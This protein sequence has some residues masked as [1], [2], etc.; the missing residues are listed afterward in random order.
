MCHIAWVDCFCIRRRSFFVLWFVL[1]FSSV[2]RIW[3]MCHCFF[4]FPSFSSYF[5]LS[6]CSS[7]FVHF[8][9][10]FAFP[11][12]SIPL[13]KFLCPFCCWLPS[14]GVFGS[15]RPQED[16][17]WS[18]STDFQPVQILVWALDQPEDQLS[19]TSASGEDTLDYDETRW[20]QR[21]C[22]RQDQTLAQLRALVEQRLE[23]P[24]GTA[25]IWIETGYPVKGGRESG[26]CVRIGVCNCVWRH[27]YVCVGAGRSENVCMN[28]GSIGF[29]NS[30]RFF[31]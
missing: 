3:Q 28:V 25:R 15:P 7:Y 26:V 23:W 10:P 30:A 18:G 17:E 13:F 27:P 4:S 21:L 24:E 20:P 14:R 19:S 5:Y 6:V 12:R 31:C 8:P 22:V 29:R 2:S 16:P 11:L 9:F 1:W